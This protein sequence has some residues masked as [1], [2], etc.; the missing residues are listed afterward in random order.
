MGPVRALTYFLQQDLKD[1]LGEVWNLHVSLEKATVDVG[2][3]LQLGRS[4]GVTVFRFGAQVREKLLQG[5]TH[6]GGGHSLQITVES[7]LGEQAGV[8]SE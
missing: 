7:I 1:F 4:V 5:G 6:L 2:E 3:V 8:F